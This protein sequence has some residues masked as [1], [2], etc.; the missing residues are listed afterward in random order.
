MKTENQ[1]A[2]EA[3]KDTGYTID[4]E[5]DPQQLRRDFLKRFGGYAVTVPLVTFTLMSSYSSKAVASG[6]SDEG[7]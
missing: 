4:R 5:Q 2:D 7:G 3:M 6:G 1:P